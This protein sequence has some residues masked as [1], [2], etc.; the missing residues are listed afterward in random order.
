M[1]VAG[2]KTKCYS[3][4][5]SMKHELTNGTGEV[6]WRIFILL[7]FRQG[8]MMAEEAEKG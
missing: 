1:R 2:Q 7:E 3:W 6:S 8:P 4:S 5:Q